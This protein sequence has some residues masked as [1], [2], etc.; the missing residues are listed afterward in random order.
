MAFSPAF[1]PSQ[2][3]IPYC[4]NSVYQHV[5]QMLWTERTFNEYLQCVRVCVR[6]CRIWAAVRMNICI[7]CSVLE[8]HPFLKLQTNAKMTWSPIASLGC[9]LINSAF[10]W[11]LLVYHEYQSIMNGRAGIA[12]NV[13]R[14]LYTVPYIKFSFYSSIGCTPLFPLP[15][16]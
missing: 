5:E 14:M 15:N 12:Y 10:A 4:V 3:S 9:P 11:L 8:S 1:A 13:C 7:V 6:S 16:C 2:N